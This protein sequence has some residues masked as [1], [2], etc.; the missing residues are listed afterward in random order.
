MSDVLWT[1]PDFIRSLR[2]TLLL[3][4][5]VKEFPKISSSTI[6]KYNIYLSKYVVFTFGTFVYDFDICIF[7]LPKYSLWCLSD[8]FETTDKF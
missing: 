6:Q 1:D 8:I 3:V 2:I 5:T 7:D 4:H